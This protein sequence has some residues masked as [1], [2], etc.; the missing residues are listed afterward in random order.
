VG[1]PEIPCEPTTMTAAPRSR[2][3]SISVSRHVDFVRHGLR[4]RNQPDGAGKFSPVGGDGGGAFTLEAINR[5]DGSWILGQRA[6]PHGVG[7]AY[8]CCRQPSLPDRRQH[9]RTP[10]EELSSVADGGP[11][12][13]RAVVSD[14]DRC[15]LAAMPDEPKRS[16]AA[17][18]SSPRSSTASQAS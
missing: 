8:R 15:R 2:A 9:S 11:G 13:L 4:L 6:H 12:N 1:S 16:R 14:Q 17:E 3:V 10:G 7:W 18:A 5:F